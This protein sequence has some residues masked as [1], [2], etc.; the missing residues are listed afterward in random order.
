MTR[1]TNGDHVLMLLQEQLQRID[2][3]RA[4]RTARTGGTGKATPRPMARLQSLAALD[5]LSEEDV[6]RTLVRALLA[7]ELGEG[8]SND[9][10]FQ[11][12]A[13]DVFRIMN[14]SQEGRALIDRAAAQLRAQV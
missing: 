13:E 12:V 6:R 7:E 9:P 8:I 1:I 4:N 5:R 3:G 11:G 14:A 10:A 2:R